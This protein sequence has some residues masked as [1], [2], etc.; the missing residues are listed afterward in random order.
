MENNLDTEAKCYMHT[1]HSNEAHFKDILEIMLRQHL[2][3]QS[4]TKINSGGKVSNV[5]NKNHDIK[6]TINGEKNSTDKQ[7][8]NICNT[9]HR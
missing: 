6:N 4:Y 1:L 2:I 7:E 8:K 3:T 5:T 9:Y